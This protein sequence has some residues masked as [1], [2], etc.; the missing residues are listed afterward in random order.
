MVISLMILALLTMLGAAFMMQTNTETQIAAYDMRSTQALYNAEAGY[1]EV[2]ARFTDPG[3]VV[4][5]IGEAPSVITPGW[6]RYLVMA[7][8]NSTSDEEYSVPQSDGLDNDGDFLIDE[9]GET[10]PEILSKQVGDGA[11]NYPWVRVNYKLD[12]AGQVILFGDHDNDLA[13]DPT[14]NM[15]RGN[16]VLRI[17]AAG[18][19][20]SARR[21]IKVEAIRQPFEI[22]QTAIYTEGNNWVFTGTSFLISGEDW[23]P[24]TGT[25]IFGSTEVPGIS[26]IVD[27]NLIKASLDSTQSNRVEGEGAEPSVLPSAVDMHV[28]GL[29]DEYG[30]KAEHILAGGI[31]SN[32]TWGDYDD[33]T[34]VHCTG[35]LT[36]TGNI[37]GY[38]ILIVNGDLSIT[39]S[40]KWT[41]VVVLLGQLDASAGIAD[42]RIYG[43][44]LIL[45][46]GGDQNV[47]SG[48]ARILYSSPAIARLQYLKRYIVANWRETNP[49][50]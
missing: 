50:Y 36:V 19:Q 5:Y 48:N 30:P 40:F 13:T 14:Y 25:T 12:G 3:D 20:G 38:G 7:A 17:V 41:G 49:S 21:T 44:A 32:T 24:V 43:S 11:I 22:P 31:Y 10:Y 37:M 33:Y 15:V 35:N 47:V 6:G 1:A 9:V 45:S 27:P 2:L 8:G 16:P 26:T 29:R 23:D 4:N 42:V 18:G 46:Q 28:M 34:I 39:G